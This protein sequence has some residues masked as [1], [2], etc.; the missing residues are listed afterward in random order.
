[1]IYDLVLAKDTIIFPLG[2]SWSL[3]CIPSFL[4]WLLSLCSQK[5]KKKKKKALYYKFTTFD[6]LALIIDLVRN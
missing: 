1:M 4:Q 2:L 6:W 5:K 3:V